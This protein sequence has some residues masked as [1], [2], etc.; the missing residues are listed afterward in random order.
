[1]AKTIAVMFDCTAAILLLFYALFLGPLGILRGPLVV[2]RL[3]WY[4]WVFVPMGVMARA[5]RVGLDWRIG[6]FDL[7]IAQAEGLIRHLEAYY[8]MSSKSHARK[9]VLLDLYTLLTRAYLHV[10]HINEAMQVV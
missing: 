5:I 4:L 2:E 3:F 8:A 9:R 7:A 6:N 10:G 1:M